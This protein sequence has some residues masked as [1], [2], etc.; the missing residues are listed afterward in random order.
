M[1]WGKNECGECK[2]KWSSESEEEW[3]SC[4]RGSKIDRGRG[5]MIHPSG[6]KRLVRVED[7]TVKT[8][9]VAQDGSGR[10]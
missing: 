5:T 8:L 10:S 9:T 7:F 1:R 3:C 4:S 2:M 6:K